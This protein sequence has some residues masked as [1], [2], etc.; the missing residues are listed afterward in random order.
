MKKIMFILVLA[1]MFILV[2]CGKPIFKVEF[3]VNGEV[4]STQDIEKGNAAVAPNDPEIEGHIFKGWDK[5]FSKVV[6]NLTVTAVLEKEEFTIIFLDED[7]NQIKE[8]KVK[9]KESATAPNLDLEEGY[10]LTGWN[11]DFSSVTE[12]MIIE[13]IVKRIKYTVR[14]LDDEGT[15]LKEV[16][17]SHGNTA[18]FGSDPKKAGYNFIGWDKEIKNVTSNIDVT[19][20]FELATYTITY[21]D[22]EGNVIEGLSPSSYTI[23]DD[24]SLELPAL[25]EKEGYECLGWYEGNTRVVTFF[26][27]DAVNKVY[28]IK[29]KELPKPLELPS[30]CTDTFK[31]IKKVAH[32]SGNGTYVYQPDFTG[33][34]APSTSVLSYTWS[35]LTPE[36]VNIS[37]FS[38]MSMAS[39][40]FGI[41][42]AVYNNDPTKVF[43]AVVKVTADGIFISSIEEA[44]TKV[45]YEVTFTDENGNIIETQKVEEGKAAIAPTPPKKEGY[46]FI[47]W[48]GDHF[49]ISENITLEPN[50]IEGTSDFAGKTVS[51]LGDSGSTYKGYVPDGYSCFY[52][53]PTS[54]FGDVN[55][56][57][58]MRT[59]NNLGMK[60]LKNN[61]WSGSCVS[62]GTGS[63]S[64]TNDTR[65][66]ELLF[67]TETPDVIIIFMGA[68]DC[69]SANVKLET[70]NESYKVM[71]DKIKLLCPNSEIYIMTLP[72]LGMYE[73]DTKEE[74]NEVIRKYAKEYNY[75]LI[76]LT[77][78]YT[79]ETFSNYSLDAGHPNKAGMI[80]ISE[81]V[82]K[83]MLAFKNV[84]Y[85]INE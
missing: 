28:T 52:P 55:Q 77:H 70:F 59:I 36:I 61:S 9:Y 65:L 15:V 19:A 50:Y 18:S 1:F 62:T 35:S 32:S 25:I 33:V 17:V 75:G 76:E 81:T 71:L 49:N 5:D 56:T 34:K 53:Y 3:I 78:L 79:K 21:K 24:A 8:E 13:P 58:W 45:E 26:S 54:D 37:A 31:N 73:D 29:Y 74:Y 38:S 10:E 16:T 27:S 67:G 63:S 39:S 7:Q 64:T 72:T 20:K 22:E 23:L 4:V 46:T 68:N 60:L 66:Q 14:F 82:I 51:I 84:N 12:D 48:S 47:G 69:G 80:K 83:D 57:W 2:G 6:E 11:K 30:D 40:G 44:N 42:K 43:Y 41:I 85:T